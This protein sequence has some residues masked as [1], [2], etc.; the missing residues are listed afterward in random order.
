MAT[1]KAA[2][3][4]EKAPKQVKVTVTPPNFVV[5]SF[6]ITG[7]APY[8]QNK[9]SVKAHEEMRVKQEAGA[10]YKA[11]PRTAKDFQQVYEDATHFMQNG[12][13]GIPATAFR[14]AIIEVSL[15]FS[16]SFTKKKM[17]MCVFVEADGIDPVDGTPLVAFTKGER[18]YSEMAVRIQQTTD[19]RARPMWVPGW[20]AAVRI[21]YDADAFT[22]QEI[23]NLL[24]RAGMQVG[25]GEGR[26]SSKASSGMGW[27]LFTVETGGK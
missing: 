2:K 27:G 16:R 9:F 12:E 13:P 20:Q 10:A 17:R 5:A 22:L 6:T 19:I 21:Q 3:A 7:T 8:V 25:I 18:Q 15:L 1:K 14:N 24:M 26:P 23:T 4:A 11:P